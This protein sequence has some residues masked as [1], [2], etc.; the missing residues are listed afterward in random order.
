MPKVSFSDEAL[1]DIRSI[2]RYTI[3]QWGAEQARA[4]VAGLRDYCAE[5]AEMPG[6]GKAAPWLLDGLRCFPY[7]S[8][9]IYYRETVGGITIVAI[10]HKRQDPLR[11]IEE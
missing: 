10:V 9:I 5:I 7:R 1:S 2:V 6:V 3:D 4:Y 8:H 11:R